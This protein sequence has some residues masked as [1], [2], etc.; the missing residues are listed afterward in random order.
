MGLVMSRC[1]R[2]ARAVGGQGA[3]LVGKG[4]PPAVKRCYLSAAGAR[5]PCASFWRA[6]CGRG[7][8]VARQA[9]RVGDLPVGMARQVGLVVNCSP[10][11]GWS[12]GEVQGLPGPRNSVS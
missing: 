7:A 6:A 10:G 2:G 12:G 4:W 1:A 11:R 8:L 3:A 5:G 9:W